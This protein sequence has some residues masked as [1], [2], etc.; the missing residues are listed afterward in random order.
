MSEVALDTLTRAKFLDYVGTTFR[1]RREPEP[2]MELTLSEAKAL[3][4]CGAPRG[5][6][7]EAFSL[8]FHGP[9][10]FYV[11]Q[12]IYSLEHDQ[13]GTIEIFLVPVGPDERG[14]RYEAIFN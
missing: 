3:G 2:P 1:L 6:R 13:F 10:S 11:P 14:M 7:R 9:K 4:P 12:R 5:G 8:L